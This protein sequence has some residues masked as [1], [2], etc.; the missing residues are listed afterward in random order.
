[1]FTFDDSPSL[2]S[3]IKQSPYSLS[4]ENAKDVELI[5]VDY[6]KMR[7]ELCF[8][9]IFTAW[10][11]SVFV[12]SL[13]RIF[14]H[15]DWIRRDTEF[16]SVFCERK[17]FNTL[18]C[19]PFL[20]KTKRISFCYLSINMVYT[21]ITSIYGTRN[22]VKFKFTLLYVTTGLEMWLMGNSYRTDLFRYQKIWKTSPLNLL[23]QRGVPVKC[24]GH[25]KTT[26]SETNLYHSLKPFIG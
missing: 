10:K 9:N 17:I 20:L 23:G 7:K 16:Y 6:V 18:E 12:V 14:P 25:P 4:N 15:S 26:I 1:M 19:T 13:V 24:H 2:C 22:I 5:N 21:T 3:P 11:V 8:N